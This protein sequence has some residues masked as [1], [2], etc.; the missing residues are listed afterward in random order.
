MNTDDRGSGEIG[1]LKSSPPKADEKNDREI[2]KHH[3]V[4]RRFFSQ[5]APTIAP[6]SVAAW[7]PRSIPEKVDYGKD[8]WLRMRSVLIWKAKASKR[9]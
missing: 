2:K 5:I 9:D 3:L 4:L 1:V 7:L 8:F 6:S